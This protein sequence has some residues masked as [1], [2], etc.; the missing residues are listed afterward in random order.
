MVSINVFVFTGTLILN[1][2]EALLDNQNGDL[3]RR[4]RH[5]F[6]FSEDFDAYDTFNVSISISYIT[7]RF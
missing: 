3:E 7:V 1:E 4:K 6:S 5:V 2:T